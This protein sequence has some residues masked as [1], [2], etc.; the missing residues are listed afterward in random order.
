MRL[1]DE[2]VLKIFSELFSIAVAFP[3]R[4]ILKS[5]VGGFERFDWLA[6]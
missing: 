3:S 6:P 4:G 1:F 5:C 2:E